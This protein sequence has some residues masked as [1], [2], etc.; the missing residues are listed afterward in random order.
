MIAL[1]ADGSGMYTLQSLWTVARE[2]AR[3]EGDLCANRMYRILKVELARADIAQ[4]GPA[5]RALTD[6]DS[7]R[8]STGSRSRAAWACRASASRPPK[9]SPP[10]S[11]APSSTPGPYLVEAVL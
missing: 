5:A 3:R 4:P 11:A 1:Q 2:I 6:L 7:A 8:R 10:R 9:R